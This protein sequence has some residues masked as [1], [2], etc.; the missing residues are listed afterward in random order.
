MDKLFLVYFCN[1]VFL[2]SIFLTDDGEKTDERGRGEKNH[3]D[4]F[5]RRKDVCFVRVKLSLTASPPDPTRAKSHSLS[6]IPMRRCFER[7]GVPDSTMHSRSHSAGPKP[8]APLV[9]AVWVFLTQRFGFFCLFRGLNLK[10]LVFST[11]VWPVLL[12]VILYFLLHISQATVS[13][14]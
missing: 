13:G 3:L 10:Y 4:T 11:F 7:T 9:L 8:Q 12:A 5:L 14:A 2:I 6:Q 1:N